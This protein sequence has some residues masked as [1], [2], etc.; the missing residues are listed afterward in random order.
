MPIK[1]K[2][3]IISRLSE[4]LKAIRFHGKPVKIFPLKNSVRPNKRENKNKLL[5]GF[6]IFMRKKN[7]LQF[8]KKLQENSVSLQV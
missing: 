8:H 1:D 2:I 4:R 7:M 6:F 5:M 3:C